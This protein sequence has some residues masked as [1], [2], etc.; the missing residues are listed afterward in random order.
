[1]AHDEPFNGTNN[2]RSWTN[3]SAYKIPRDTD[4]TNMLTNEKCN[5]TGFRKIE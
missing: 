3:D 2:C 5:D 4:G 1:M